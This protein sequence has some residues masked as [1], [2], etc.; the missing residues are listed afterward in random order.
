M[1]LYSNECKV[2][3]KN[4]KYDTC[5]KCSDKYKEVVK[6]CVKRYRSTEEGHKKFLENKKKYYHRKK[7]EASNR[8]E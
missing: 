4:S 6:N 2:C 8:N 1:P 3:G 7:Q 5:Y